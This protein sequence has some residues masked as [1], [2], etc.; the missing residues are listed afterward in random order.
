[1]RLWIRSYLPAIFK[2]WLRR[3]N[4]GNLKRD[5]LAAIRFLQVRSAAGEDFYFKSEYGRQE[6]AFID[7]KS[8]FVLSLRSCFRPVFFVIWFH[9]P[10]QRSVSW[11]TASVIFGFFLYETVFSRSVFRMAP[12]YHINRLLISSQ[13][14]F[15]PPQAT[16][17]KKILYFFVQSVDKMTG[18]HL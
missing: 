13:K 12:I 17:E 18:C 6:K 4:F 8:F 11:F 10:Q 3:P 16:P 15:S 1:M 9:E 14:N 2:S 5:P 7:Y